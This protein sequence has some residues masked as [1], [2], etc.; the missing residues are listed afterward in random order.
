MSKTKVLILHTSVGHGIKLTALNIAE[1]LERSGEFE[2]RTESIEKMEHG[3]FAKSLEGAYK[4]ILDRF[5]WL[6]GA[7]YRSRIVMFVMM[8]LRKFVASF[9]SKNT[10]QMLREF[11]PA[12]VISTQVI[13]TGIMAYLKSKGLYRGRLVAVFSD[14]HLHPFWCFDEVDLYF[15]NIEEQAEILR[16]MKVAP[17]KI[18]VTGL[19]VSEKFYHAI[20]KEQAC[21]EMNLLLTMP[22]V[23]FFSGARPRMTN[24]EIFLQ[25]LR[26]PRSFQIIVVCGKNEELKKNWNGFRRR[27][28]IRSKSTATRIKLTSSCPLPMSWSAKPA[29]RLWEKLS[30]SNCRWF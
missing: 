7:M 23:F 21:Q 30:S 24:K 17:E 29:V 3:A 8:P 11:Q 18:V 16:Q 2:T 20:D 26:S 15:C 1:Q 14:Y 19:F 25:L 12:I 13:T 22:K 5:G 27:V 6:W 10:L 9:N 28:C 4:G